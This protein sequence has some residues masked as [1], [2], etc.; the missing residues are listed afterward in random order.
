MSRSLCHDSR[1]ALTKIHTIRVTTLTALLLLAGGCLTQIEPVDSV[2]PD[3]NV[4]SNSNSPPEISGSPDA[5]VMTND[6]YS[7]KPTT[8]DA[9]GDTLS[10]SISGN[11]RWASFNS[12]TGELSG[13]PFLGDEGVYGQIVI[14]ATDGRA[15]S[16]LPSF[17]IEVTQVALG[18]MSL[19]WAAPSEN[20]DGTILTDLAGYNL[21]Y[22][23]SANNY[24]HSIRIDN[25]SISTYLVENLLPDTYYVVAT[26]FNA[27]GVESEFSN[28]AT[29]TVLS[30]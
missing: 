26:S 19:F 4:A 3:G 17:A 6:V 5:A 20:S 18:S 16:A 29:R 27:V 21:Y 30:P 7:F 15:T 12:A 10:F 22:G 11:P 14:S 24:P 23:T 9:D 1:F 8:R 13:K 25:P 2:A 28:M